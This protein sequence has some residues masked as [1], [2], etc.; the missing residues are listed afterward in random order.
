MI[1][2]IF[3]SIPAHVLKYSMLVEMLPPDVDLISLERLVQQIAVLVQGCWV[4][5]RYFYKFLNFKF[6]ADFYF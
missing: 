6:Y 1:N 2:C 5:K 3:N 4:V